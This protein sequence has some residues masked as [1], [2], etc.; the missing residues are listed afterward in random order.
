[1]GLFRGK[2]GTFY[3]SSPLPFVFFEAAAAFIQDT[4]GG[5]KETWLSPPLALG[6]AWLVLTQAHVW[7]RPR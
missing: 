1:M 4:T 3:A 5:W 2:Q 6:G 7:S